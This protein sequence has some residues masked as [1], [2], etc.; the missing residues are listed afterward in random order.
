MTDI[1]KGMERVTVKQAARELNIDADTLRYQL[2]KG[3]LQTGYDMKR[4]GK[5]RSVYI[6]YRGLLEQEKRRIREGNVC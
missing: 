4:E 2:M 6:I 3:K 5:K 1:E